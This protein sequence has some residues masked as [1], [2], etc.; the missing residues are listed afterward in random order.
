MVCKD[1][2]D[3]VT[4][5][6]TVEEDDNVDDDD[7]YDYADDDDAANDDE[8]SDFEPVTT[9]TV[10][11]ISSSSTLKKLSVMILIII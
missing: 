9:D 5:D 11:S 3:N 7:D 2:D 8:C 10:F 4:D 1:K 6:E